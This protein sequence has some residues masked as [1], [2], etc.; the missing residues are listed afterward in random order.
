MNLIW[1]AEFEIRDAGYGIRYLVSH[2]SHR[3]TLTPYLE[4]RISHLASRIPYLASRIMILIVLWPASA[5][6]HVQQGEA[7]GFLTGF[8]SSDLGT[9]PRAGDGRR[10]PVGRAARRPRHLGA[11]GC[12]SASHG[13]GRNARAHG[14]AGSGHRVRDRCVRHSARRR[15]DCSKCAL[16]SS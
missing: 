13:D 16:R 12:V 3:V 5:F 14:R 7:A 6:A 4:S 1:D 11:A 2:I 15:G 10:W 9:R 8:R